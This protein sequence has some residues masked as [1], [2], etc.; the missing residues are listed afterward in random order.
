MRALGI[1]GPAD[2][3]I[4]PQIVV[5][6]G[7]LH[8]QGAAVDPLDRREAVG[9]LGGRFHLDAALIG[10][11]SEIAGGRI[12]DL[13]AFAREMHLVARDLNLRAL[14][15]PIVHPEL[16]RVHARRHIRDPDAARPHRPASNH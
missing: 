11:D 9:E 10:Q 13:D 2:R 1:V 14:R 3:V 7:L 15:Q 16:A 6:G 12:G 5:P 8:H 4:A